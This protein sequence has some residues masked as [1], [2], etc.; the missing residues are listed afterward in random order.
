MGGDS[1]SFRA[2]RASLL[3]GLLQG[4][5][6]FPQAPQYHFH[7]RHGKRAGDHKLLVPQSLHVFYPDVHGLQ[8]SLQITR[9]PVCHPQR[10]EGLG[11][12]LRIL[13]GDELNR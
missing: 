13:L 4:I 12:E 7:I 1:F 6:S 11:K 8:G 10:D 2:E 5:F 3:N 9:C